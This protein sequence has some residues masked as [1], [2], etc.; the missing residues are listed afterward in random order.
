ME[1][2]QE[3]WVRKQTLEENHRA[4]VYVR[5]RTHEAEPRAKLHAS[6]PSPEIFEGAF[7]QQSSDHQRPTPPLPP[8]P[9][10][11]TIAMAK[12]K[13]EKKDKSTKKSSKLEDPVSD[14]S[15]R[16][17]KKE[18]KDKKASAKLRTPDAASALLDAL[19]E[20]K[21]A[22][23]AKMEGTSDAVVASEVIA[24][25]VGA[26]VAAASDLIVPFAQPLAEDK[27][28]KKVLKCVK[29]GMPFNHRLI[30]GIVVLTRLL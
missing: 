5:V 17:S 26:K 2:L 21:A 19:E 11:H 20:K 12:E 9:S 30:R 29:K 23:E 10:I 28:A 3:T 6:V 18:K 24:D 4:M 1:S 14:S 22:A 15:T 13:K 27:Q 7:G 8:P 25:V 16:I